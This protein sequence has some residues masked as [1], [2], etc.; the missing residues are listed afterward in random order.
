MKPSLHIHRHYDVED[1]S[2]GRRFRFA[3]V[4]LDKGRAYPVNFVCMLPMQPNSLEKGISVFLGIFGNQSLNVAK[5]MLLAALEKET[6]AEVK[7]EI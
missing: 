1:Y 2:G 7:R 4:D 3:V 6:D 5:E